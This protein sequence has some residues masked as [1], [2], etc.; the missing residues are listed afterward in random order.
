MRETSDRLCEEYSLSVLK[1]KK[2]PKSNIDYSKFYKNQV[3]KSNYHTTTKEDIDY[4]IAQAY[5]YNDFINILNKMKYEVINR[6]G[7]L[8]VRKEPYKRNIRIERAF[9]DD[10]K[11][12][13]IEERIFNTQSV[14]EPFPEVRTLNGRYK[15]SGKKRI[16]EKKK[17]TGIRALYFHYC[18]LLKIFPKTKRK[19]SEAMKE[20]IQKMEQLSNE[21]R[22]LSKNGIQTTQEFFSYKASSYTKRKELKSRR[23]YLWKKYNKCKDND[24]KQEIYIEIKEIT[25]EVEILNKE[26]ELIEDI[27]TRIPKIKENIKEVEKTEKGKEQEK[28]ERIK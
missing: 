7:K 22:F 6:S 3:N 24:Q 2:C 12:A 10:Y 23:A 15:S 28:D 11:I 16:R 9:G 8:S 20:D 19:L 17:V 4:A 1:E 27:E 25:K 13:N 26:K 14:R 21:A 5:S 18:Y